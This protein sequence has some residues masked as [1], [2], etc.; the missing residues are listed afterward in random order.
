MA[1]RR[2]AQR[3]VRRWSDACAAMLPVRRRGPMT[4]RST[5]RPAPDAAAVRLFAA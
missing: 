2:S 3:I 5:F 1:M 4:A